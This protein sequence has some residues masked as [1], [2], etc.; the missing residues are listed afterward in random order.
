[1]LHSYL[2]FTSCL[3]IKFLTLFHIYLY[4]YIYWTNKITNLD[5]QIIIYLKN[6]KPTARRMIF[7]IVLFTEVNMSTV[8]YWCYCFIVLCRFDIVYFLG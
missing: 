7:T 8:Y 4:T 2:K 1:M 5:F 3:E 6:K